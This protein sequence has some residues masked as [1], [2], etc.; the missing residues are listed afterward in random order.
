MFCV[1]HGADHHILTIPRRHLLQHLTMQ[2]ILTRKRRLPI[3]ITQIIHLQVSPSF[4]AL[5]LLHHLLLPS[6]L[7]FLLLLRGGGGADWEPDVVVLQNKSY[8]IVLLYLRLRNLS[9][10]FQIIYLGLIYSSGVP[11]QPDPQI[12]AHSTHQMLE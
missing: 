12:N 10:T 4:H 2:S 8:V 9:L 3:R 6:L 5:L 1:A 11:L 7:Q